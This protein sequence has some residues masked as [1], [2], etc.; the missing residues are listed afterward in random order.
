MVSASL[1]GVL[2]LITGSGVSG[3][4]RREPFPGYRGAIASRKRR[5]TGGVA[6]P[7]RSVRAARVAFRLSG[8]VLVLDSPEIRV[9]GA[10]NRGRNRWLAGP[11]GAISPGTGERIGA[12]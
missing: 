1:G 9:S 6:R 8:V 7:S 4:V 12:R 5:H 2:H 3:A 11:F 10:G